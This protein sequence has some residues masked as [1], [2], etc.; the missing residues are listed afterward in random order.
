MSRGLFRKNM[1]QSY[2]DNP[3]DGELA[4]TVAPD[5]RETLA[6]EDPLPRELADG[7]FWL[8]TCLH[9]SYL[10][11]IY[12]SYN[13]AYLVCGESSSLLV[14]SGLPGDS[15]VIHRQLDQLFDAGVPPLSHVFVTHC[16]T[17]HAGGV[18][19]LLAKYPNAVA[20]GGVQNLHLVFPQYADRLRV[21]DDGFSVDL[22]ER[23]FVV[24]SSALRDLIHTQWGF[25]ESRRALFPGD[26]FAYSH[27]HEDGHCGS[28]AEEAPSL[29]IPDMT[30]LF[31]ELAL[32]WTT[33][34]DIEPHILR[35]E[36][37]LHELEVD[38]IGPTHGLP[39]TD[40]VATVP[41]VKAG[42]RLGAGQQQPNGGPT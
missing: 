24:V 11:R 3:E 32:H 21:V 2:S 29:N 22:G 23:R 41:L 34:C 16:E 35:L 6:R 4:M 12:H 8:G 38:L 13:S 7:L 39:V 19:W 15:P 1:I 14:E 20:M 5:G 42:L 17:P 27:Y 28:T 37:L 26:G 40:L 36:N 10:G 31:A 33:M 9:Q 18:G 30:A 25:D